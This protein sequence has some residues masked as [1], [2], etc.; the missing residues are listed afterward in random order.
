[1]AE[2]EET[3]STPV[4]EDEEIVTGAEV[5]R[6][7]KISSTT[8]WRWTKSGKLP[9]PFRLHPN[10]PNLYRKTQIKALID[11]AQIV[12]IYRNRADPPDSGTELGDG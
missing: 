1:M 10:G 4:A 5:G 6:W 9:T 3:S 8:R 7:L 11:S 12:E 2:H